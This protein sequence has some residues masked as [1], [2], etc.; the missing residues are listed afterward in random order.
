MTY[1]EWVAYC[2]ERGFKVEIVTDPAAIAEGVARQEAFR[3]NETW[4]RAH[5]DELWPLARGKMLAVAG[6]EAFIAETT[7]EALEKA[8]A[9]HPEERGSTVGRYVY[10]DNRPRIQLGG[11]LFNSM[12]PRRTPPERSELLPTEQ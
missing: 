8:W 2:K 9:A 6:E 12:L 10:P 4:M 3:R 11:V 7:D 1:E 5:W